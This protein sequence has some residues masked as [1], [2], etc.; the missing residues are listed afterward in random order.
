MEQR[1]IR[2]RL[3]FL[4]IT[5]ERMR[6]FTKLLLYSVSSLALILLYVS[7]Q[8]FQL[9]EFADPLVQGTPAFC[10][11][12][13]GDSL[14]ND[15][16]PQRCGSKLIQCHVNISNVSARYVRRQRCRSHSNACTFKIQSN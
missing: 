5:K 4:L 3:S 15:V 10:S 11:F 2:T 1:H 8:I 13:A 9:V 16:L 12:F 6:S 7:N 14:H